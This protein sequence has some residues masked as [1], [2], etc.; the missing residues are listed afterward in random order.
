V[1]VPRSMRALALVVKL[2]PR[3]VL[4]RLPR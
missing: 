4:R 1:Y 2:L 3:A